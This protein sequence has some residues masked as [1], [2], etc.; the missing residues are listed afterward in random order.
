MPNLSFCSLACPPPVPG[1]SPF[2]MISETLLSDD[3]ALFRQ[4][5][6]QAL[7]DQSP[8]LTNIERQMFTGGKKFAQS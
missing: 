3:L 2:T 6:D 7:Q 4:E 1:E 8:Y 5:I